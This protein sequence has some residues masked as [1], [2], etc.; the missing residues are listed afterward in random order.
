[1][2]RFAELNEGIQITHW[3]PKAKPYGWLDV[4]AGYFVMILAGLH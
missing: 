1:V 2:E 3:C 4:H